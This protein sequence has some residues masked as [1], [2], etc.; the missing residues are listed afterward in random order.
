M[1][2]TIQI[3]CGKFGLQT[4]TIKKEFAHKGIRLI[5]HR[6]TDWIMA[7]RSIKEGVKSKVGW[8]VSEYT[9]G[10]SVGFESDTMI[11]AMERACGHIN[12][13][14][15]KNVNIEELIKSKPIINQ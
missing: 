8:L 15:D 1:A 7:L 9:S 6:P 5:V 13:A 12:N 14:L 2:K 11:K 10:L 4:V 3:P